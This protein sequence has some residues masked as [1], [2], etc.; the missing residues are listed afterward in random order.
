MNTHELQ[1]WAQQL[2][3]GQLTVEQFLGCLRTGGVAN[4]GEAQLDLDRARR[5]GFPEV[6]FAQGK[7]VSAL[8]KIFQALLGHGVDVLATRMSPEQAAEL[9]PRF[10]A[11]RYNAVGRTFRIPLAAERTFLAW[12]R[13]GLALMGFGFVVARFGLFLREWAATQNIDHH[14]GHSVS[15]WLGIALV[16]FGVVLNVAAL[17]RYRRYLR[18]LAQGIMPEAK[19]RLETAVAVVLSLIGVAAVF[20]LLFVA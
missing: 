16:I 20:Y 15:L 9:A 18:Q 11:G 19:P 7:T 3:S 8:E 2:A 13:T 12:I 5:C 4:V 17:V 1:H 14:A 6:I 10:T